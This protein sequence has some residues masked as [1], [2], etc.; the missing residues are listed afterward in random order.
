M[1]VGL[2][3]AIS[4]RHMVIVG[5]VVSIVVDILCAI[6]LLMSVKPLIMS[7]KG[8]VVS[9]VTLDMSSI[10]LLVRTVSIGVVALIMCV[11]AL[12]MGTVNLIVG[13][14]A[15]IVSAVTLR[16][17]TKTLT[18]RTVGLILS[19][20]AL[21]VG[22]ITLIMTPVWVSGLLAVRVAKPGRVV[23]LTIVR[24]I[25]SHR[26]LLLL[27]ASLLLLWS[28]VPGAV[29]GLGLL[30]NR[31]FLGRQIVHFDLLFEHNL[32]RIGRFPAWHSRERVSIL[33]GDIKLGILRRP[34]G[35]G[36]SK[37]GHWRRR[38][39]VN[40]HGCLLAITSVAGLLGVVRFIEMLA[41][42]STGSI[43]TAAAISATFEAV[44][45]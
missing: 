39:H 6:A 17:G 41:G 32:L 44:T 21:V 1:V 8:L 38:R 3:S 28:A 27:G 10:G 29:Y 34:V 15:L 45:A 11:I 13:A 42:L 24:V 16:L 12:I 18:L 5:L 37:G 31:L 14:I 33:L 40:C 20:I 7:A 2:V 25:S 22:S 35:R 43:A 4:I 30:R 36:R 26:A 19:S 9:A 23:L